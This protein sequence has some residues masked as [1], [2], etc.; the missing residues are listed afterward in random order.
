MEHIK[1][2][3]VLRLTRCKR[4][5][6]RTHTTCPKVLRVVPGVDLRLLNLLNQ[7]KM[8]LVSSK[9]IYLRQRKLALFLQLALELYHAVHVAFALAHDLL[10]NVGRHQVGRH[11]SHFLFF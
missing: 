7:L 11:P 9:E 8:K 6:L 2:L 10:E 5:R 4:L 1:K 3:P